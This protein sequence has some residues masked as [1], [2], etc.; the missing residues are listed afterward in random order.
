MSRR[1]NK[2]K[3]HRREEYMLSERDKVSEGAL[4]E[5]TL[6][7]LSKFVN[8]G[9]ITGIEHVIAT[10]KESDVFVASAGSLDALTD[11]KFVAVKIFRIEAST[12]FSMQDY[13]LGDPRFSSAGKTKSETVEIWC[14][15]E[16]GNLVAAHDAGANVP[17][18]YMHYKNILAMEFLGDDEG[19]S[20]PRLKDVKLSAEEAS[21]MEKE[22]S[23]QVK[24]LRSAGL[25]HADLS[26]YNILVREGKPYLID[27]AQAVSIKH[28][29]A[30][31]FAER[32][33]ENMKK[34]FSRKTGWA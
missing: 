20:W 1:L 4:S 3:R 11:R 10:G 34:Y 5:R 14:R 27:M 22:I 31:L 2:R 30:E 17:E 6:L 29:N 19:R 7:N 15:K 12:F 32:D 24:L 18:P 13:I 16:Y 28:P 23:E 33:R 26:E 8:K 9:I 25:V 21:S